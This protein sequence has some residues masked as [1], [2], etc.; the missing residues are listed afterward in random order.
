M[1]VVIQVISFVLISLFLYLV[2]KD[3]KSTFAVFL[4]LGAGII[5]F[6]FV[7]P[8]VNEII[9]FMQDIARESGMDSS[10]IAIV[11]KIIAIAY[12]STFCSYICNDAGVTVLGKKVEFTGKIMI[13][14]LAIPIMANIL[15][16][17]LSIM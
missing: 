2:L 11:M 7:M 16:S 6:L 17:I 14:L 10:Y 8:Y 3:N 13:L 1:D 15:N 5:I 4:L 9:A 12:L